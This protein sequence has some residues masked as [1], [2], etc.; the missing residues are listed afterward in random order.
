MAPPTAGGAASSSS[1]RSRGSGTVTNQLIMGVPGPGRAAVARA[2]RRTLAEAGVIARDS[3]QR[4]PNGGV[5]NLTPFIILVRRGNPRNIHD[6]ADLGRPRDPGRPSGPADLGRSQLGDRRRVRQRR[7]RHSGRRARRARPCSPAS[8]ATSSRRRPRRARRG[9]SSR[10]GSATR[11]ITYEQE[12]I[13][14]PGARQARRR[15]RLSA[16]RRSSPSTRWS[17]R[18]QHAAAETA[19]WS[20]PSCAFSGARRRSGSSS[21]TVFAASTSPA[22]TPANPAFGTIEDPF[23]IARLGRMGRGQEGDRGARSGRTGS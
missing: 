6:F 14:R 16:A 11:S 21:D 9:R 8:G 18:P 19:T 15:R 20:T 1:A 17:P 4:L 3:W 5:V 10:T 7:A 12:A 2:R 23:R 22:R 13:W